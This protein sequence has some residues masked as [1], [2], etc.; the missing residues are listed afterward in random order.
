MMYDII[1]HV[2]LTIIIM[3]LACVGCEMIQCTRQVGYNHLIST[4]RKWDIFFY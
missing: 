1:L 2:Y 4:K 3:P